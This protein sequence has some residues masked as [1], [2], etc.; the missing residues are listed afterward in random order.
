MNLSNL[1]WKVLL[2]QFHNILIAGGAIVSTLGFSA[3]TSNSILAYGGIV[4]TVIGSI[5]S[6]ANVNAA[7]T[8]NAPIAQ[9]IAQST[10]S[11]GNTPAAT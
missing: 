8:P 4:L 5:V 3:A 7:G 10:S 9:S 1:N 6:G 11:P 2:D